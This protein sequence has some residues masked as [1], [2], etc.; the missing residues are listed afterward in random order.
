MD[1][2]SHCSCSVCTKKGILHLPIFPDDFELLR[3]KN[4]LTTYTF[5]M[6]RMVSEIDSEPRLLDVVRREAQLT[7]V[8]SRSAPFSAGRFDLMGAEHH[9]LVVRDI[10]SR[11]EAEARDRQHQTQLAHVSRVSRSESASRLR[12]ARS[13][14]RLCP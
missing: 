1:Q 9:T 10:T 11:R 7:P 4:S 3:G 2:L 8:P 5:G 12:W 6:S 13:G 14:S